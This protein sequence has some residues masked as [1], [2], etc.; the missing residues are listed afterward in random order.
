M[1]TR[2]LFTSLRADSTQ[3]AN[4]SYEHFKAKN[5]AKLS[6]DLAKFNTNFNPS[7]LTVSSI[8]RLPDIG[9]ASTRT[10]ERMSQRFW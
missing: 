8:N 10:T 2:K 3:M 1:D 6:P 9:N 7:S 5:Q 4:A